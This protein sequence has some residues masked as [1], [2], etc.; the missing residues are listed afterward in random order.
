[1]SPVRIGRHVAALCALALVAACGSSGGEQEPDVAPALSPALADARVALARGDRVRA[2]ERV[3]TFRRRLRAAPSDG[4]LSGDEQRLL[5][6]A[7]R[8]LE[9]RI[10][11]DQRQEAERAA[12]AAAQ[13]YEEGQGYEEE[14]EDSDD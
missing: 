9:T 13:A 8:R 3:R 5:D 10:A 1:M 2:L 4:A 7:A 12:A 11:D 6:R 14:D